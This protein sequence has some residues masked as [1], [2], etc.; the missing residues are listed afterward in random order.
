MIQEFRLIN[1]EG[2]EFV[3]DEK[4]STITWESQTILEILRE[5]TVV[6]KKRNVIYRFLQPVDVYEKK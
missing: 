1:E 3:T 6:I 4:V 5:P 2:T